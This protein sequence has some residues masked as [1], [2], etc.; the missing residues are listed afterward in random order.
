MASWFGRPEEDRVV[1]ARVVQLMLLWQ[2]AAGTAEG[3][4]AT[5]ARG[6]GLPAANRMR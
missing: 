4:G 6:H 1:R 2:G 3:A 5:A